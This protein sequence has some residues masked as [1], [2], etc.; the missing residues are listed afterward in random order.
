MV[1]LVVDSVNELFDLVSANVP[2]VAV[3]VYVTTSPDKYVF[4]T[5]LVGLVSDIVTDPPL[6]AIVVDDGEMLKDHAL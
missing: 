4:V 3:S 5:V 2:D 6:A 1:T